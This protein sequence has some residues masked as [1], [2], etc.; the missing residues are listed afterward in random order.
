MIIKLHNGKTMR[1]SEKRF[2]E[3]SKKEDNR[4]DW[5]QFRMKHFGF[6]REELIMHPS[7]QMLFF[8]EDGIREIFFFRGKFHAGIYCDGRLDE[9]LFDTPEEAYQFMKGMKGG[10]S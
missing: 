1:V 8:E 10:Q 5:L 2:C 6:S 9:N 4:E 3:Y 7:P